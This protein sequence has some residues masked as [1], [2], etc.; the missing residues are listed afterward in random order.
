MVLLVYI[1]CFDRDLESA[2]VIIVAL[3]LPLSNSF[4]MCELIN[5]N[6]QAVCTSELY[7]FILEQMHILLLPSLRNILFI[8]FLWFLFDSSLLQLLQKN[9]GGTSLTSTCIIYHLDYVKILVNC[10][11]HQV[12]FQ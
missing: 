1:N 3:A 9:F 10:Q 11:K 6:E 2:N 8:R 12:L 5:L 4:C 7:A